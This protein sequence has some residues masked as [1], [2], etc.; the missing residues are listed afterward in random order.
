MTTKTAATRTAHF[1]PA[2]FE[3]FAELKENNNKTWFTENKARYQSDVVEPMQR[4]IVDLAKRLPK[5]SKH[6]SADPRAVGGVVQL[7]VRVA[8][9]ELD[10]VP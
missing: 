10:G 2:L 9:V 7:H 4:F 1:S 8:E 3:F 5:I 6:F